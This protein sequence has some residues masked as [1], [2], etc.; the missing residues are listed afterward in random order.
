MLSS[1]PAP[2]I[3]L[4]V[5][6]NHPFPANLPTLREIYAG[7][8]AEILFL[9]PFERMD[10]EDVITVYRGS[11]SHAAFLT[12][13]A[14]RLKAVDC[15]YYIVI[16]DDVMLNPR[17]SEQSFYDYFPLGQHDGYI[18]WTGAPSEHVGTRVWYYASL[19]R[20]LYPKSMM[21]G[22][23]V[24]PVNASKYLPSPEALAR[25][26]DAAGVAYRTDVLLDD[27]EFE[28]I[29]RHGSRALLH[30]HTKAV[31]QS[32][33][34]ARIDALSTELERRLVEIM[35]A[36]QAE[37]HPGAEA[38][39]APLPF[40]ILDAACYADFYILPK[41]RFEDFVHYAGV[42]AASGVFVEI[43]VPMLLYSLCERVW[44]ADELGLEV[45]FF[46]ERNS[47]L[48]FTDPKFLAIHPFKLSSYLQLEARRTLLAMLSDLGRGRMPWPP[49]A[50]P[51]S[52]CFNPVME[53]V[54]WYGGESWG[55]WAQGSVAAIDFIYTPGAVK[56]LR[57]RLIS[58]MHQQVPDFT[59]EVRLNGALFARVQMSADRPTAE[60]VL[61]ATDFIS[62]ASNRVEVVSDRLL[63]PCEFDRTLTDARPLGFGLT[64]CAFS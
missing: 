43:A 8:F 23:G 52:Y 26:L 33:A 20:I 46:N 24:D 21:L 14:E 56:R 37:A 10:D 61:D 28:D 45:A 32:P 64:E 50:E 4:C 40:P 44:R 57:L 49:Q 42:T 22:T 12:D 54:S 13:A 7:R 1:P 25:K 63:A 17:V 58:P 38:G 41:S 62:L 2:R 9:I 34:Q 47:L 48:N 55:R 16:H 59:G 36:D 30:G 27:D 35:A 29:A 15:D 53:S 51:G 39:R 18:S 6:M 60:V 5:L 19:P 3:C 31:K 11:Y